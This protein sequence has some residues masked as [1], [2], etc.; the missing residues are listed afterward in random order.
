[1]SDYFPAFVCAPM[2]RDAQAELIWVD[3]Y[4]ENSLE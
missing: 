1:M 4:S 3:V 2:G